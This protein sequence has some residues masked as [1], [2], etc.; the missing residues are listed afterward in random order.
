MDIITVSSWKGSRGKIRWR[1]VLEPVI[2]MLVLTTIT[3][4]LGIVALNLLGGNYGL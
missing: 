3:T 4:I 2:S 1:R